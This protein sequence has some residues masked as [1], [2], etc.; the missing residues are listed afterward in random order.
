MDSAIFDVLCLQTESILQYI[1]DTFEHNLPDLDWMDESTKRRAID[2]AK[3]VTQ[4]IG[5]PEYIKDA[6]K[7]D[8]HYEKVREF[9]E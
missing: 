2:K 5:Y 9:A 6:A 1:R 8:E 4:M 3:A 7:L